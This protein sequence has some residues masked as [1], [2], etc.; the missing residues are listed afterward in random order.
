M[1]ARHLLTHAAGFGYEMW[2]PLLHDAM[3]AGMLPGIEEP[4]DGFLQGPLVADPGE[5]VA[6]RHQ[7]ELAGADCRERPRNRS[8]P[9]SGHACVSTAANGRYALQPACEQGATPCHVA[10]ETNDGT[11][12][13]TPRSTPALVTYF[14][15]GGGL[16]STAADYTR[17]LRA[18]LRGGELDGVQILKADT[19]ALMGKNQIGELEAGKMRT[20]MPQLSNDVDFFPGS[21]DHFGLG[22]LINGEPVVGGRGGKPRLG[23]ALQHI[24]LGR[25]EAGCLWRP[26]D[27]VLAVLRRQS[28]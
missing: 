25:P 1:T 8:R 24:F 6:I 14:D 10:C 9:G 7:H 2:N 28:H 22:F 19:V 15:G 12:V 27:A 26:D 18:L 5:P 17:F 13:E 3:V 23:R 16:L 4:G 11:L 20:V 21:V